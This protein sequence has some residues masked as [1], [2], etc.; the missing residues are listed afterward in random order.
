MTQNSG[1]GGENQG[2]KHHGPEELIPDLN[3]VFRARRDRLVM[4]E[5]HEPRRVQAQ[6]GASWA[7]ATYDS[8]TVPPWES[9][10][11][12]HSAEREGVL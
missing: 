12:D 2:K 11:Q 7:R 8:P 1:I 6:G 10:I 9:E 5:L 3:E 4:R